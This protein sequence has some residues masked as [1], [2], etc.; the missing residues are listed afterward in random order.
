MPHLVF[1]FYFH[2]AITVS[3][4]HQHRIHSL[5]YTQLSYAPRSSKNGL[6]SW[7]IMLSAISKFKVDRLAW[8]YTFPI[9]APSSPLPFAKKPSWFLCEYYYVIQKSGGS[10][11]V[12]IHHGV[13]NMTK[14]SMCQTYEKACISVMI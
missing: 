2:S 14:L 13:P 12:S 10:F 9:I 1:P 6:T 7:R 11:I 4:L 8:L 3:K 5:W